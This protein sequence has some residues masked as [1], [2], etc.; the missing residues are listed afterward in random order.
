MRL[1]IQ[2]LEEIS[3]NSW[4]A[5]QQVFFDG[6]ILRTADGYTKRAN[7]VNPLYPSTIN[8]ADKVEYCQNYYS[9]QSLPTIF[10]LTPAAF[11]P[12]LDQFLER[13]GFR[14]LDETRVMV[15]G[16]D[17]IEAVPSF[18]PEV[19]LIKMDSQEWL[20]I[21][22]GF[23][24]HGYKHQGKHG[25]I[26]DA[27][28]HPHCLASLFQHDDAVACGLG[29]LDGEH[30]GLFD[31]I[32]APEVRRKGFGTTLLRELLEWGRQRGATGA[33]L[34]VME[35][36]NPACNLYEK[37]GFKTRYSYWYRTQAGYDPD[38]IRIE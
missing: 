6:W 38:K 11:P 8:L 14:R 23:A 3:M 33:Y 16:L 30:I 26:L 31:L 27:I 36:N 32:T 29:V 7:S 24:E 22:N 21:Y 37:I 34:Q 13:R 28:R 35:A 5:L 12:D 4:P 1:N 18:G 19:R 15:R 10:R 20:A 17:L 25:Q 9:R 2:R